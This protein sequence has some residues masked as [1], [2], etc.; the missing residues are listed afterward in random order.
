LDINQTEEQ[1]VES[2]KRFWSDNGNAIIAGLAIGF[3][4]FIGLNYYNEHKFQQELN[5]SEAYQ[6]MIEAAAEDRVAFETAGKAFIAE[7]DA[8]G[9]TMLTAIALAKEAAKKQDWTQAE[10]YLT[11]AIEKSVDDGIKAIATVRLARVQL[12]LEKYEQA[13]V[14]LTPTLPASFD[15]SVEEIKGDIYFTQGKTE[16]ARNA[17]QAAIDGATEGTNPALQMK[18]DNLAQVINLSK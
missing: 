9:Y 7:N 5:T 2:I 3:S 14:T 1:Q 10:T 8:S 16:L 12:Q 15:A 4:G 11:T 6:T 17:Y 13:L 18:L